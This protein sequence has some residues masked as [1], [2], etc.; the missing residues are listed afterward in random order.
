M[1]PHLQ[2]HRLIYEHRCSAV[3]DWYMQNIENNNRGEWDK[4]IRWYDEL[5]PVQLGRSVVSDSLRPHGLWIIIL[6]LKSC[7]WKLLSDMESYL[8][9]SVNMKRQNAKTVW[10]QYL[11]VCVCV[12]VYI[13]YINLQLDI[14]LFLFCTYQ[15][16]YIYKL[17]I[18]KT[19]PLWVVLF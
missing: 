16:I 2:K 3:Y 8:W 10:F 14:S 15:L 18:Y 6:S 11:C 9:Y 12:C 5:L 19:R 13:I 17:Y 7:L 1:D 4:P